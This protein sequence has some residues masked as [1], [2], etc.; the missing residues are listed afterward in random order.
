MTKHIHGGDVYKYKDC[1]DFSANLNP[2]GTPESVKQA[3][4]HSLDHIAQYPRVGCGVL[5]EKIAES[6]GVK[7]E[8]VICGNGAAEVIFTLCHAVKPKRAL[9]P[10][11][12][13][14]E[15]GQALASTGCELEYYMLTENDSFVL[16]EAYL[17][18][19]HKGL[20]MAFLC[21]PNNPTGMLIPHRLL[22]KILEKC[23]KLDILL[24]VD[25]CFL[26]FVKDPEEYSLKRSLSDA[27]RRCHDRSVERCPETTFLNSF[28]VFREAWLVAGDYPQQDMYL[29]QHLYNNWFRDLAFD[30]ISAAAVLTALVVCVL[31]LLLQRAWEREI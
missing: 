14:A 17:D 22:K 31:I 20:D 29:L 25:E 16:S 30:K 24:V 6:E 3:I 1:L 12:T 27:C 18:I 23:R 26:D 2:L 13:F 7:A 9:I 8:E 15:Y 5:R 11:P 21:N 19:L 10:A 28:K 4:I